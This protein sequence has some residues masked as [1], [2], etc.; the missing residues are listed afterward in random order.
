MILRQGIALLSRLY[1][2]TDSVN[3]ISFYAKTFLETACEQPLG[4]A[5][6][7][8]S[9]PLPF[10]QAFVKIFAYV[11][12]GTVAFGDGTFTLNCIVDATLAQSLEIIV[13]SGSTLRAK[14]GVVGNV[15]PALETFHKTALPTLDK[16]LAHHFSRQ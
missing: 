15:L 11:R 10:R 13:L 12:P 3:L 9:G 1:V 16:Q 14:P 4:F 2:P 8:L 6:I 5:N 7:K